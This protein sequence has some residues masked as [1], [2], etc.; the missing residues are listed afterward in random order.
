L[1]V[2]WKASRDPVRQTR[3]VPAVEMENRSLSQIVA[4]TVPI[5]RRLPAHVQPCEM[6]LQQDQTRVQRGWIVWPAIDA[7]RQALE[8]ACADIVDSKIGRYSQGGQAFGGQ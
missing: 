6:T 1:L 8:P 3:R 7:A 5:E 2:D 4:H